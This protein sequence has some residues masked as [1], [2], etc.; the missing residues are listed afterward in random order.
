MWFRLK[1]KVD[2]KT[3]KGDT[4]KNSTVTVNN[5]DTQF[6]E[7]VILTLKNINDTLIDVKSVIK[8]NTIAI[9]EN[10]KMINDHI[11]NKKVH[12]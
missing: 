11:K 6:N 1:S 3:S 2:V 12:K 4:I 8:N 7:I 5:D 10:H 9:K